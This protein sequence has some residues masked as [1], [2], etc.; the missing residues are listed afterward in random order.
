MSAT[1]TMDAEPAVAAIERL[2][3]EPLFAFLAARGIP[4]ASLGRSRS[5]DLQRL[6]LDGLTVWQAD[7]WACRLGAHPLEVWGVAWLGAGEAGSD[8]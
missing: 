8:D 1:L 5:R 3:A 7:K 6:R 4:V 2:S